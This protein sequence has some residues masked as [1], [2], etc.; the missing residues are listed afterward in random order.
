MFRHNKCKPWHVAN[1]AGFLFVLLYAFCFA[2]YFIL[3][4]EQEIHIALFRMSFFGFSGMN[5]VSFVLGAVQVYIWGYIM[6]GMAHLMNIV[7]GC[8]KGGCC[9]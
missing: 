3:P 5:F 1:Y 9:K 6:V 4:V 2:W 8:K 7:C